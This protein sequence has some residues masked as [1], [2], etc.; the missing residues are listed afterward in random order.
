MCYNY[1]PVQQYLLSTYCMI[2]TVLDV[3]DTGKQTAIILVIWSI[4][5]N[6]EKPN[7]TKN[8]KFLVVLQKVNRS[9]GQN[10]VQLQLIRI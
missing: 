5:A 8:T 7:Y 2:D 6:C 4:P 10:N 3:E 9:E 1:L